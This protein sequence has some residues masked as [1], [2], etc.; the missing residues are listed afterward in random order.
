MKLKTSTSFRALSLNISIQ[1]NS[2]NL[3]INAPTHTTILNWVH[4]VGYHQLMKPKEKA[5]DWIM[6]IDESIQVGREKILMIFGIREKNIDFSRPLRFQDLVPIRELVNTSWTGEKI[7]SILSEIKEELG[8]IK[9]VVSDSGSNI[10]KSLSLSKI[11]HVYDLTHKIASIIRKL[12]KKNA[13]YISLTKKMAE[14]RLKYLQ[15][16]LSFLIPPKQRSQSKYLNINDISR[17]CLKTLL[18]YKK[19]KDKEVK[20]C[21]QLSWILEYKDFILSL[22]ELNELICKIEKI[23]K[24][25]GFS[26]KSWKECQILLQSIKGE[27]GENFKEQLNLYMDELAEKSENSDKLLIT[28]DIIE[29]SF[30][31]YKNYVS[32]NPMAGITNLIL[33]ISAF[34]SSLGEEEIKTA[35][36]NTVI[37]DVKEW[38]KKTIGKSLFQKRREAYCFS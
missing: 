23:L 25:N 5:D 22:S 12:Y 27:A 1:M 9:Y 11:P 19:N 6:I 3:E 2:M 35:L 31:K 36:E 29:S 30:G 26:E 28:S 4:K 10:V 38:T 7:E 24:T 32:Q 13:V 20:K 17:W 16:E 18:Y 8:T 34:T 21:E 14:M 37:N 15:T 33:S